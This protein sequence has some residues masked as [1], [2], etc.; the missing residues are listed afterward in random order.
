MNQ[1][2]GLLQN[3]LLARVRIQ[4]SRHALFAGQL[5]DIV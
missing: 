3:T 2:K 1:I 4:A 5:V